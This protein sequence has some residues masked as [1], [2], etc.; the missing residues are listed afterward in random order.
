MIYTKDYLRVW[1]SSLYNLYIIAF[2]KQPPPTSLGDAFKYVE[3][4][5]SKFKD[6]IRG[7]KVKGQPR[8]ADLALQ[9]MLPERTTRPPW[10]A[11]LEQEDIARNIWRH[12]YEN[13]IY[14][15]LSLS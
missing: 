3:G 12:V 15:V 11:D 6:Y 9:F 1:I 7:R 4:N 10:F 14:C 13:I 8:I 2:L 5:C